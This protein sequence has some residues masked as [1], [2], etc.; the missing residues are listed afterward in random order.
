VGLV[1]RVERRFDYRSIV[2]EIGE[3]VPLELD[4]EREARMA[5]AIARNLGHV[6]HVVIPKVVEEMVTRHVLVTEYLPGRRLVDAGLSTIDPEQ[7]PVLAE[8]IA[9]AYGHQVLIDGLFQ[10]DPHPGNVLLLP[11]GRIALLDF[12][13]TK[14]LPEG[15]RLRFAR[16]VLAAA[17]RDPEAIREAFA[18][19]GVRTRSD[20]P[21]DILAISNLFFAPRDL[22]AGPAG[23]RAATSEALNRN[24]V[25]AIPGDLV[26][27]GRVVGLL[28]GVSAALG[29][30]LNP[31]QMLRPFAEQAL[32]DQAGSAAG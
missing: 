28:R 11:D 19:L 17:A 6:P 12:G 22:A 25:D 27:L 32:R 13:L 10:A 21:E 1:A 16:L 2:A 5:A 15:V 23:Y 3:Q 9:A 18:S 26:L 31:M 24:P 20:H 4:F 8:A 7:G 14:E 30:A 29:I